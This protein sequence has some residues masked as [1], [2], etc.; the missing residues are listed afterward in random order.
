[1]PSQTGDQISSADDDSRL[2]PAQ[3][4]VATEQHQVGTRLNMEEWHHGQFG[5]RYYREVLKKAAEYQLA[6]NFHE[7]I[8][9]GARTGLCLDPD[10]WEKLLDEYYDLRGW[11]R[12]SIPKPETLKRLGLDGEPSHIL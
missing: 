9:E 8:K 3:E 6:V 10:K 1:M 11:D 4:L 12:N 5:V 2:R 7:P